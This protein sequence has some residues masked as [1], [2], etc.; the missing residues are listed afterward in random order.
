VRGVAQRLQE[1]GGGAEEGGGG[2]HDKK[3]SH[4]KHHPHRHSEA[5]AA[6][7]AAHDREMYGVRDTTK[8]DAVRMR[9]W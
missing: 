4:Q 1:G 6:D 7:M 9:A 2:E 8:L 5:T 3:S